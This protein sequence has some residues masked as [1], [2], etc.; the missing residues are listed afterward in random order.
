[1]N[2]LGSD[3][4]ITVLKYRDTETGIEYAVKFD[5]KD[6]KDRHGNS[7]LDECL[8]LKQNYDKKYDRLPSYHSHNTHSLQRYLVMELMDETIE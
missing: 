8:F 2:H 3:G 4:K 1:M 7:L 5:P 6:S